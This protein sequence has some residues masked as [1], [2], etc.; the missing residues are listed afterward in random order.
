MRKRGVLVPVIE[1]PDVVFGFLEESIPTG[2]K[3]S[4]TQIVRAALL[5]F[6]QSNLSDEQVFSLIGQ[7]PTDSILLSSLEVKNAQ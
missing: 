2:A 7:S 4:P 6:K 3:I 5:H 1:I